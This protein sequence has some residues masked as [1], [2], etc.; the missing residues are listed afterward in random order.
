MM[1]LAIEQAQHVPTAK[2]GVIHKEGCRDLR[3]GMPLG[4]ASTR[5]E[6]AAIAEEWMCWDYEPEDWQFAPCV[7]F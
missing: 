5:D 4:E 2:Y 6:A 1:R 7:K 3:D